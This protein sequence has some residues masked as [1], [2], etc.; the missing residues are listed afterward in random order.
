MFV[1]L[2][3]VGYFMILRCIN[4]AMSC[5]RMSRAGGILVWLCK[6]SRGDVA[7]AGDTGLESL[8]EALW[9]PS[10]QRK[11]SEVPTHH[12][13]TLVIFTRDEPRQVGVTAKQAP[14]RY[15]MAPTEQAQTAHGNDGPAREKAGQA[16][17]LTLDTA[18]IR[19]SICT[20]VSQHSKIRT[21][22]S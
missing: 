14:Y 22:Y 11:S 16:R 5:L 4:S 18:C 12:R 13:H 17:V 21:L 19:V 6:M 2:I 3:R 20:A 8:T 1:S 10:S 9:R 7:G 15:I